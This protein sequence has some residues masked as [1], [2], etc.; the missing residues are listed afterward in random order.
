MTVRELWARY[1]TDLIAHDRTAGTIA[2][3]DEVAKMFDTAFGDRRLFEVTTSAIE[4]FLTDVGNTR[5]PSNM[6]TGRIVC[7]ECSVTPS[8]KARSRS[9]PCARPRCRKTSK[10]KAAPAAPVT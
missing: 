4:T 2:R 7:P 10:P 9:T 8:A 3:Y 1:R 6:R 5:G